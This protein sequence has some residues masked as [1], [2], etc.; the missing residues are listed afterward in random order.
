MA[1]LILDHRSPTLSAGGLPVLALLFDMNDLW[2]RYVLALIRRVA[3]PRLTVTGQAR[4]R[5]WKPHGGRVRSVIPD[6]VVTDAATRRTLAVLDTK[7]K[8]PKAGNPSIDDLRQ[9]FVYNELFECR[10]SVLVYPQVGDTRLSRAGLFEKTGHDCSTA[11][12][13]LGGESGFDRELVR[14]RAKSLL[15]W[16]LGGLEPSL[17][18]G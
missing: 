16:A 9:M 1:R 15:E 18:A 11:F 13:G 7:W 2:E 4:R 5:F 10:R 3:P 12:L 14:A 8:T 6:I 17:A